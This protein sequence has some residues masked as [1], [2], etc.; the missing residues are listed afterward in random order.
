[1]AF[2]NTSSASWQNNMIKIGYQGIEGSNNRTATQNIQNALAG[3][4]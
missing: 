4:M 3:K 2:L 1:M